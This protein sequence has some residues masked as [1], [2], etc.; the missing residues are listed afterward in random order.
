MITG[1]LRLDFW[2]VRQ[3]RCDDS[4]DRVCMSF[5]TRHNNTSTISSGGGGKERR[6]AGP[7]GA[8]AAADRS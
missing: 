5:R 4:I 2:D 3:V 6:V 1:A 7:A 8:R